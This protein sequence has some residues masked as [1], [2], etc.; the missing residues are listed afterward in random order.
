MPPAAE[1]RSLELAESSGAALPVAAPALR[2][3]EV[4]LEFAEACW[5]EITDRQGR[6][7]FYGLAQART[8]N[9]DAALPWLRKALELTPAKASYRGDVEQTLRSVTVFAAMKKARAQER[10]PAR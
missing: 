2:A 8:G 9:L 1:E 5:T 10:P 6:R 7:V 3:V 4:E